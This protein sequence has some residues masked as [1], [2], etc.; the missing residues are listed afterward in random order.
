MFFYQLRNELRK[1]FGKKRTYLGFFFFLIVQNLVLLAFHFS[2]AEKNTGLLLQGNGYDF[3]QYISALTVGLIMLIPQI[4]LLMPLYA[5]LTGGDIVAKEVE[6]GTLRMILAR[7]ISR[8]WLLFVKW[9]AGILFCILLVWSLG[10]MALLFARCWFPWGG[11]FFTWQGPFQSSIFSVF[12]P[13]EGLRLYCI[14]H[15][16]LSVVAG[17][18][19]SLAFM[20]SCF[21][22]KPATA[23]IATMSFMLLNI[24]VEALPFFEDYREFVLTHQFRSWLLFFAEPMQT[25]RIAQS[26]SVLVG[27]CCLTFIIGA[28]NFHLRDIKS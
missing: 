5:A 20:F 10:A 1:L 6:D 24:V 28:I 26:L 25:A 23:T 19:F 14:A 2:K 3:T 12:S 18:V 17:T 7:P 9:V 16:Y 15:L 4:M 8:V 21:N 27:F 13:G 11:L 22:M